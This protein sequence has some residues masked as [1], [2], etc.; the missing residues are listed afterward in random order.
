MDP[1]SDG[2]FKENRGAVVRIPP[3]SGFEVLPQPSCQV[4]SPLT[5]L[6]RASHKSNFL[7]LTDFQSYRSFL[8]IQDGCPSKLLDF[9]AFFSSISCTDLGLLGSLTATGSEDPTRHANMGAFGKS[10]HLKVP[11][12][13]RLIRLFEMKRGSASSSNQ[14]CFCFKRVRCQKN[15]RI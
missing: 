8:A 13:Q 11:A 1:T 2:S 12:N 14:T 10:I 6:Q 15:I 9:E 3:E 4:V 7:G 5:W